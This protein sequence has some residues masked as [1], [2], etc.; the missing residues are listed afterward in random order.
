[1]R[2]TRRTSLALAGAAIAGAALPRLA[3]A[4]T[5]GVVVFAAAS[6]KTAL[7]EASAAWTRETGKRARISYAGSN[8]LAKQVEAGAPA[9][10]FISADLDWMDYLSARNLIRPETRLNLLANRLV[11][12]APRDSKAEVALAPGLDLK[13]VL[14]GERLAMAH[15]DSVPAGRYGRAALEKLGAWAGVKD[16]VAQADNVRAALLLV[17]RGEAALG[18][19]YRTDAAAEP[20]VRILATFAEELHPPVVYPAAVTRESRNPDAA[21]FLL[22]LRG[23][24]ARRSFEAQGFAVLGRSDSGS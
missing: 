4:Q 1:M 16:R 9:D 22:F 23:A 14:G 21:A 13:A 24:A 3:F 17:A 20:N 15:V 19:V 5:G 7:D 12:V 8:T 6:L 11:L 18:I 10:L 2:I